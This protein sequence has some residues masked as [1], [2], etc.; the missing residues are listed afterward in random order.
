MVAISIINSKSGVYPIW[1]YLFV[2]VG[3]LLASIVGVLASLKK[4]CLIRSRWTCY[5]L[6][7]R[8]IIMAKLE[9]N[10]IYYR[11]KGANKDVL[12]DINAILKVERHM[13]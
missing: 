4:M 8:R 7:N 13:L 10:N 5:K 11:Y 3:Y 2:I 9:L 6:K 12:K 1:K